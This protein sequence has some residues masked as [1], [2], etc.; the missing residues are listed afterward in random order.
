MA[1]SL[2]GTPRARSVQSKFF[3]IAR[4]DTTAAI[5]AYL[6]KDSFIVGAYVIGAA[7]SDA[8]TSA[9]IGVGSTSSANEFVASY[10]VKTAATGEG[11]NP[12]GGAAVGSA[13]GT[14]LTADTPIYVKYTESGTASTT[15][16]DWIVKLE[17]FVG[18]GQGDRIDG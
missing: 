16:G 18:V 17:Y 12:V 10:D 8:A 7:A 1:V 5:R 14:R 4:T 3:T 2:Y 15:G 13:F 9:V 11:Y 6:P